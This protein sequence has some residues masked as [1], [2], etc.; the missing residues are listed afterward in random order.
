MRKITIGFG[1]IALILLNGCLDSKV[2]LNDK[3]KNAF[4]GKT[5][6]VVHKS[7][8]SHPGMMGTKSSVSVLGIAFSSLYTIGHGIEE[9]SQE[10]KRPVLGGP[11]TVLSNKIAQL[12][13]KKYGMIYVE[14]NYPPEG[15]PSKFGFDE[16]E[17]FEKYNTDYVLEVLTYWK[18]DSMLHNSATTVDLNNYIRLVDRR[19]L[20]SVAKNK[21]EYDLFTKNRPTFKLD[22]IMANNGKILKQETNKAIGLCMETVNSEM[23]K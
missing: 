2:N 12:L 7:E 19:K 3:D 4:K 14:N 16:F 8:P 13:R 20:I 15:K 10:G 17:K 23:F 1:V 18:L 5:F 11:S 21:C 9:K 22:D 6:T